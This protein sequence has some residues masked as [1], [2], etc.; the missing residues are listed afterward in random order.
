MLYSR[1]KTQDELDQ[2]PRG[3]QGMKSA[4]VA[5]ICIT[6]LLCAYACNNSNSGQNQP[7]STS[8]PG[9]TA[10]AD[11]LA[12]AK[13]NYEKHCSVC[14]GSDGAGG[15]VTIEDKKLKVPSLKDGHAVKHDDDKLTK[16]IMNGDEEMPAFKDKLSSAEIVDLVRLIRRFQGKL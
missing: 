14:H 11:E 16:Q 3:K 15:L 2:S 5:S 8:S 9:S 7:L 6:L 10:P 4:W 12:A 13:T 1:F